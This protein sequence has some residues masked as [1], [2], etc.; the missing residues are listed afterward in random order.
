MCVRIS[1]HHI[2]TWTKLAIASRAEENS[3]PS[4]QVPISISMIRVCN[5]AETQK[6]YIIY[7]VVYANK[8]CFVSEI[9]DC[10]LGIYLFY[11]LFDFLFS[12]FHGYEYGHLSSKWAFWI[13]ACSVLTWFCL[14]EIVVH[15]LC[16]FV[17]HEYCNY[18]FSL[19]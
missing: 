7:F 5:P 17:N 3:K 16:C 19:I 11:S 13:H 4:S 2:S 6:I 10:L 9:R 18:S 15:W 1:V 8:L 14:I 12:F